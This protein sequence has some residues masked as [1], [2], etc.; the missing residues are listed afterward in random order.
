M[1]VYNKQYVKNISLLK[2]LY[3]DSWYGNKTLIFLHYILHFPFQI[4]F[5]SRNEK[6]EERNKVYHRQDD[7]DHAPCCLCVTLTGCNSKISF[8]I[9]SILP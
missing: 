6:T 7:D 9:S 5:D 4:P 2:I 1:L 8:S 3:K